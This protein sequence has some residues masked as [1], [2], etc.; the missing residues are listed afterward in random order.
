MVAALLH[1]RRC[2]LRGQL[3][4]P[5]LEQIS[6]GLRPKADIRSLTHDDAE[7]PGT[8]GLQ[9]FSVGGA[10]GSTK[11]NS[12]SD[13]P[14]SSFPGSDQVSLESMTINRPCGVLVSSHVQFVRSNHP[15]RPCR[16]YLTKA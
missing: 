6:S 2:L 4:R 3:R 16:S 12:A 7:G 9:S 8:R 11:T 14:N 1:P 10:L 5:Q 15:R 13:C